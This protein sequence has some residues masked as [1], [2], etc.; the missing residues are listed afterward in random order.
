MPTIRVRDW[1][2]TRLDEIREAEAHSSH[3][4]VVK[5]LLKDREIA[6]TTGV[7]ARTEVSGGH[8]T[9][10]VVTDESMGAVPGLTTLAELSAP[11][12]GVT[13]LWCPNCCTE[14]AH[15]TMAEPAAFDDFEIEC[16]R[17]LTHLDQHALVAIE[18]SYPLEIKLVE[19][20]LA[21]D[22]KTCVTDYWDR[23][24]S[25]LA[26]DPTRADP[27]EVDRLVWEFDQYARGFMW[28]WPVELPVVS[29]EPGETY[30]HSDNDERIEIIERVS[31]SGT[32]IDAFRVE[33]YPNDGSG[34]DTE[35]ELLGSEAAAELL[36]NR[37]LRRV[38]S[39]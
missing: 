15:F 36:R 9:S 28:E 33:R 18:L 6:A 21:A 26:R 24:L 1:T 38:S 31:E 39:D 4:S 19:E 35:T 16:Q 13:F 2:K 11:E 22:L 7:S 23:T 34:A 29:L 20:E 12:N 3:D 17:C 14:V 32:T 10:D 37:S 27:D 30:E 8:E 25:E 5:S